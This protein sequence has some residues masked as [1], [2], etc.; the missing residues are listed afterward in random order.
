MSYRLHG[1]L[2]WS[3]VALG[4]ASSE[5]PCRSGSECPSGICTT[6]GTCAELRDAGLV[7]ADAAAS[8]AATIDDASGDAPIDDAGVRLCSANHDGVID[9]S[10]VP[11][12]AG[13]HATFRIAQNTTVS[14]AG[15]S[16]TGTRVWDLSGSFANDTDAI[17]DLIDPSGTWWSA[18]YP[19][20]TYAAQL[21]ASS[22]NLGVFAI[23]DTALTLLGVVSEANGGARTNLAY[24]P[25]VTVLQFPIHASDTWTTTS[26]VTG[27][28][29]G[30]AALY[31]ETY[32]SV[33]DATGTLIT[34]LGSMDVLRVRTDMQRTSGVVTLTTLR[35]FGFVA[36]CFG[37]AATITSQSNPSMTEFTNASE[38]RRLAP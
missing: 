12:R 17:V 5:R 32:T 19:T 14:T 29:D 35:T 25:P 11:L 37:T 1:L 30:V 21:A 6:A 38:V 27:Q 10:E 20:A 33:V 23:S 3:I 4:C 16:S 15:D 9:R 22:T 28:A 31:T 8:D 18:S 34:P 36:E 13:L 24:D 7:V 2:L 26:M